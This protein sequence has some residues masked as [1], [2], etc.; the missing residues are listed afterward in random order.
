MKRILLVLAAL[1]LV[2]GVTFAQGTI[3]IG[4]IW[5]LADITGKQG[6]AAARLAIEEINAAGGVLGKNLELIVVDDEGKADK[7]AAAVEK[8]AT[9]DK[10]EVFI[11]GM[12]SGAELGKIP[13]FKKY[14]KVVVST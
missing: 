6:S 3:K 7:A 14:G 4:G 2:L 10:V 9:V 8:L 11:G 13:A 5:T 12:G 1:A